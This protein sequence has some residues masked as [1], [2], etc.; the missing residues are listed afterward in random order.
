[1]KSTVLILASV[2][3]LSFGCGGSEE[4]KT[5]IS[6]DSTQTELNTETT[7]IVVPKDSV[8][9]IESVIQDI[10]QTENELDSLLENL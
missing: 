4:S 8:A 5:A 10:K 9:A 3:C 2:T 7:E 6:A 1:M